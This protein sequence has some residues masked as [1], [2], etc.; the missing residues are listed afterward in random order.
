[1]TYLR[2]VVV[3][4]SNF[5]NSVNS[6]GASA[7][8]SPSAE[9]AKRISDGALEDSKRLISN[10]LLIIDHNYP[11]VLPLNSSSFCGQFIKRHF[12]DLIGQRYYRV[13]QK[14]LNLS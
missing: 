13:K 1:M 12:G 3:V 8:V 14:T 5:K 4:E 2:C 7:G 6:G 9:R 11:F 10:L